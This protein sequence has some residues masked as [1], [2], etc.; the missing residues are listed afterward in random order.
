MKLFHSPTSPYVRKVM[1]V[2]HE[3]GLA[4]QVQIL[5]AK[6]HPIDRDPALVAENPL[7]KVPTLLTGDGEVL[8]DSRVICDYLA[9]RGSSDL[10]PSG[11]AAR[12]RALTGQALADGLLDAAILVRYEATVKP[13]GER[14]QGWID[15]QLF[16][17]DGAVD[18]LDARAEDY[19]GRVDIAAISAACAIGYLDFRFTERDWRA[20][21]PRLAEWFAGFS[22]RASMIATRP[23][24]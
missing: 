23:P 16:K 20:R 9:Q 1:V 15:A 18:A 7:G 21:T 24:A 22:E 17:I 10:I 3:A 8:F 12:W 11:G 4:D 19:A 14:S 6:A 5:P 13:E 2:A